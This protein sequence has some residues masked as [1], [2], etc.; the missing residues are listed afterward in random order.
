MLELLIVGVILLVVA[1]TVPGMPAPL[2]VLCR[3]L[4]IILV[5]V[6]LILLVAGL[7]GMSPGGYPMFR[8]GG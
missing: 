7:L 3:V 8:R 5:A 6:A 2:N 4:G 1:Y